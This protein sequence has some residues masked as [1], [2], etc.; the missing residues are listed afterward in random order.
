MRGGKPRRG[1]RWRKRGQLEMREDPH[2]HDRV[3]DRY[4]D[5]QLTAAREA[6]GV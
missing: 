5:V 2:D 1:A 4:D 6:L 3:V